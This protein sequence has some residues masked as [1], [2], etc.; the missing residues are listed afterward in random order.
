MLSRVGSRLLER[1]A[2]GL[3]GLTA[4]TLG[5]DRLEPSIGLTPDLRLTNLRLVA[6]LAMVVW[7][8]ARA[9]ARRW[10]ILPR[11]LALPAA[12]WLTTLLLS[13]LLAPTHQT[14]ALAFTRDIALGMLVGWAAY[15][16]THQ[17]VLRQA[18]VSSLLAVG[19]MA[20]A[21]VGLAEAANLVP[22]VTWLA[23]FRYQP[24]FSVG[25][26]TRVASS[27]AHPNIA[28]MLIGLLV[29]LQLAW[30]ATTRQRLLQAVIAAGAIAQ[31]LVLVLTLSRAGIV[32][33]G[34]ELAL[35][36][37]FAVR[38]QHAALRSA[39]LGGALALALGLVGAV[40]QRPDVLLHLVTE[41]TQSWYRAEYGVP[42]RVTSR[43][44]QATNVEVRLENTGA[45]AWLAGGAHPFSL[46]YHLLDA[47]SGASVNYDGPRTRLPADVPPGASVE[48]SAEVLA[49]RT[50]GSYVLEWD[51]VEEQV[52]WFSW[53]GAPAGRTYLQVDGLPADATQSDAPTSTAPPAT[54][55]QA[56][57]ARLAE[58]RIAL[59][60]LRN[61]PL[62]GQGPDNF[63]WVYGDF[64]GLTQWDTGNHANSL[65]F[66]WLA[67]TG[68]LGSA[69]FAWMVWQLTRTSL[70]RPGDPWR[71]ALLVSLAAWFLHGLVDYFYEPLGTNVAFWLIAALAVAAADPRES[72]SPPI[73]LL[74]ETNKGC[75]SAST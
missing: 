73:N 17:S 33:M 49:P 4:L 57:P 3:L 34:V 11:N 55:V 18:A 64:A 65:Y 60:M 5:F 16:L 6:A 27:L 52:T 58:W 23:G 66:E 50:P 15:D 8:L 42:P 54:S 39:A 37:A 41:S 30:F 47:S 19:G 38:Q 1:T 61:R 31:L 48:L 7:L 45:R 68:V 35:L 9:T 43:P 21:L 70:R 62:L 32:V 2:V 44:G 59:R 51:G 10:P 74:R 72:S 20:V 24:A 14:F 25:D 40:A 63:R 71:V 13:A 36:G 56:P 22:V 69:A 53:A 75:V 26:L 67:D 12:A 46:S 29:P 28:A